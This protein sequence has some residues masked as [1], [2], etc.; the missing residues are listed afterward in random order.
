MAKEQRLRSM[1]GW[2]PPSPASASPR[3][4]LLAPVERCDARALTGRG[5]GRRLLGLAGR[6]G[7]LGHLDVL[8]REREGGR[9]SVL[10]VSECSES[11]LRRSLR[12]L[13]GGP[14]SAR[15]SG[16]K[17][18]H[19]PAQRPQGPPT[20]SS[21]ICAPPSSSLSSSSSPPSLSLSLRAGSEGAGARA[22]GACRRAGLG[23]AQ[24]CDTQPASGAGHL[25]QPGNTHT[26]TKTLHKAHT[27]HPPLAGL[28][29]LVVLVAVVPRVD[30]RHAWKGGEEGR[31]GERPA[32]RGAEPGLQERLAPPA[33]SASTAARRQEPGSPSHTHRPR[34]H[35]LAGQPW[36]PSPGS[37][38]THPRPRRPR[39]LRSW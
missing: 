24:A 17:Q 10:C 35:A 21:T 18:R 28:E 26:H 38:P 11:R 8:E 29:I 31:R 22:F 39:P 5:R 6:L 3:P 33:G 2:L 19:P 27:K 32:A 34:T 20:S 7:L 4:L 23:E 16:S 1:H 30:A 13:R 14:R 36:Q 37:P 9:A 15:A 25:L 12:S